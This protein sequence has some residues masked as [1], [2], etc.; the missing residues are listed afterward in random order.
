MALVLKDS[1]SYT[2]PIVYRQPVSGGR[3]EKQEFEA[4]FKR[5]PQSRINAIQDLAQKVIDKDPEAAEISDVSIADEVLVGWDGIVDS[6][7]EVIP[8]SKGTK[9]QLLE[10]PMMAGTLIEAYFTSLVEE[11]R[12]N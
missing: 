11:K 8:Y 10:L 4:E 12:K 1:D 7:G 5:L 2:W 6:D 9:A 3:R